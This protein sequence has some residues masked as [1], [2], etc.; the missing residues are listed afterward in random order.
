[1]LGTGADGENMGGSGSN[2]SSFNK[3]KIASTNNYQVK[4]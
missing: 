1:M 3:A 4:S 2:M